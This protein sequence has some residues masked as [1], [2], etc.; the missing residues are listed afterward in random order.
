VNYE[1][2]IIFQIF[3]KSHIGALMKNIKK[4]IR[5]INKKLYDCDGLE[6]HGKIL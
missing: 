4:A 6:Y 1:E 5:T 3:I 2:G